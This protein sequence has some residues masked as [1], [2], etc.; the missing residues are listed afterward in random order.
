M[1]S[2]AASRETA[3]TVTSEMSRP[4]ASSAGQPY[5]C[6]AAPFQNNTLPSVSVAITA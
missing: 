4:T 2:A 5:S 3:G 6:S 1:I